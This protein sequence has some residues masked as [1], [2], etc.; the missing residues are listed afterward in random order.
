MNTLK[1]LQVI[2][3]ELERLLEVNATEILVETSRVQEVKDI[4]KMN[5][6]C[7]YKMYHS[8][9]ESIV[10]GNLDRE[11]LDTTY[12]KLGKVISRI[13]HLEYR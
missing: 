4:S 3:E 8:L 2:K 12:E 1:K 7:S 5:L 9:E 11:E 10:N 13:K 6:A